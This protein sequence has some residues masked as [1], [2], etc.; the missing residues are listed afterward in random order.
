MIETCRPAKNIGGDDLHKK[1]SV[2]HEQ[3]TAKPAAKTRKK[4]ERKIVQPVIESRLGPDNETAHIPP[5]KDGD[6]RM[7]ITMGW[8]GGDWSQHEYD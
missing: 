5:L 6:I 3:P 8:R 1:P 2:S 7:H 4:K